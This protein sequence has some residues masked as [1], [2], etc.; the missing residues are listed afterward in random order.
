MNSRMRGLAAILAL[1]LAATA[2]AACN[3]TSAAPPGGAAPAVANAP[4]GVGCS[5]EIARVQA[6]L[7][8][9][10]DSGNAARS[11]YTRAEPEQNRDNAAFAA[12]HD[13]EAQTILASTKA[14]FGYP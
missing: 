8:S 11:V 3:R 7:K 10:V 5:A 14:R 4:G 9:D 1:P 12:G 13:A 2:L 6:V